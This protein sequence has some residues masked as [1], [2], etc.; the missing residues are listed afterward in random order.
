MR[1]E[2]EVGRHHDGAE[3]V[4]EVVR[5]V[6]GEPA[7]GL[8]LL[9]LHD[10]VFERA[11]LGRVERIDDR[12]LLVA[13]LLLDR[14][15]VEAGRAIA[16]A[17][18]RGIDRGDLALAG[19]RHADRRSERSPVALG[20]DRRIDRLSAPSP[21]ST[22]W[23]RRANRAFERAILPCLSTVAIAIGVL[24]KNRT[25][26]TSAARSGSAPP[27]PARLRTSV[28]EGP[29]VPSGPN[30]TLWK[31]R[32]GTVRPLLVL[33][34]MSR[35]FGL[36][37]AGRAGKRGQ[38]RGAL[39][40][41]DVAELQPAGADLRQIVAEPFRQGGVE[42]GQVAVAVDREEAGR[43]V[44][45]V[46]DCVLELLKDVFL[47]LKLARHVGQRPHRQRRVPLAVPER[48]HPHAQPAA[49]LALVAADPHFLLQPPA[50]ARRPQQ[51][52]D[53]LRD[54]RIADEHPLDRP[55]LAGRRRADQVEIGRIGVD[56]A[57]ARIGNE[58][59]LLGAIN[60]RLDER[61]GDVLGAH[62]Q[63]AGRERE[64]QEHADHGQQRQEGQDIGL[65]IAGAA[66]E[67][68]GGRRPDQQ[69]RDRQHE[70]D[71][72]AVLARPGTVE[73][74]AGDFAGHILLRHDRVAT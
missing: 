1:V 67:N 30:T 47:P 68:Q 10:L 62:A 46:I 64:Q 29:A 51:A 31:S 54:A 44:V 26:R 72:A 38:Q 13:L 17:V 27:S 57:A 40:C 15:D 32:T 14:G 52:I 20:D 33:R 48:P 5:H 58:N 12:R 60:H 71:A 34:S 28:R 50:F 70:A 59:R 61:V 7:D 16:R 74:H 8:H 18:E 6:A 69:D 23:N 21:L 11:L 49:G 42:V 56:H 65:G 55:H 41:H 2:Q 53:R 39:A 3:E 37:V 45:E 43:G 35:I 9:L 36:H 24:W 19:G 22:G 66:D 63:D 4:V 73:R 25:K